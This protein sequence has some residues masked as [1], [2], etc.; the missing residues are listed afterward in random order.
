MTIRRNDDDVV[1]VVCSSID[2]VREI[3]SYLINDP[4]FILEADLISK[5]FF[6]AVMD[7]PQIWREA[8]SY[9]WS[10]KWGFL[11]RLQGAKEA[12]AAAPCFGGH[13]NFW[14][15]RYLWQEADAKRGKVTA[16][17][18]CQLIFDFRF[19]LTD[20]GGQESVVL[21]TGL[22]WSASTNFSFQRQLDPEGPFPYFHW[23]GS[24]HGIL[25]GH[26]SGLLDLEWF[27]DEDGRGV[28]WGR[29]PHLWPK[30]QIVRLENWGWEIRNPN[31]CLR[32]TDNNNIRD[33]NELWKDYLELMQR[34][35]V[36]LW[37]GREEGQAIIEA[38]LQFWEFLQNRL[39]FPPVGLQES[40]V[41]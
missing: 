8:C 2:L 32:A 17:E 3:L 31:V 39:R 34:Q 22:A 29:L 4:D 35:R 1:Q 6:S 37:P 28:Q 36:Q 27:L 21:H 38:P 9:R 11:E 12:D 10:Q 15:N 33:D 20:V 24:E 18:L 5:A 19:W 13:G 26:P 25:Q 7:S 41:I 40:M 30:G 14:R 23:S 16:D